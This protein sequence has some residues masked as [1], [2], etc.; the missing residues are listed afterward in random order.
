[1]NVLR[2]FHVAGPMM[3]G[4][5]MLISPLSAQQPKLREIL[6]G[7]TAP[8]G[9]VAFSPDGKLLA[10]CGNKS[11]MLRDMVAATPQTTLAQHSDGLL[12]LAFSPDGRT[13]ASGSK[14]H[15]IV[16]F[17]VATGKLLATLTGHTKP[18]YS[19]AYSPDGKTLASSAEDHLIKL[20]DVATYKEKAT[21]KDHGGSVYSV[22]F[23]PDG[24]TL[25]SGSTDK[26][27]KLWDAA[28]GT[29]RATL[30]GHTETVYC[31]AFSPDGKTLASGSWDHT[32]KLW[33][34]ATGHEK[35]TLKGHTDHVYS[36]AFSPD[37]QTLASGSGW[38]GPNELRVWDVATGKERAPVTPESDVVCTL[39]YSPDGKTL[40]SGKWDSTV[41][42][43]DVKPSPVSAN[44]AAPANPPPAAPVPPKQ[45]KRVIRTDISLAVQAKQA[46][47]RA[48]PYIE[49][50]GT[51]WIKD[52]KC[53]SC[54]YV[55]YMV[56][57]FHDA[58]QRGF[59]IDRAKLAE[60]TDWSM[61]HAI[62]QGSEGPA[63][64]LLARDRT[65]KSEKT[66]TL[67]ES[68]RDAI[69]KVQD[70]DG[71][72][73][74]GGQLPA[75]KRPLSETTQVS[76][77]WNV[78]ALDSID[79]PNEMGIESRDKALAWLNKTPPNGNDPAVSSEW[80]AA[81]LLIDKKFGD[82][83]QVEA[84]RDKILAAQHPDGGWG[85]LWADPSDAFGTGVSLYALSQAGVPNSSAPIQQAWKFLI[86]TQTEEGSWI[87]N[88][89]KTA[90]KDKP[91]P[92]S[93]FWGST[94]ALLGLS[95]SVSD[96]VLSAATSPSSVP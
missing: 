8:V 7:H 10:S 24:K 19:V 40:A 3:V 43:W 82:A 60:W 52:R 21:L 92:F 71:F 76:T 75:Q 11:V 18:V 14:D 70:K 83:K 5:G 22:V 26:T 37:G 57:S 25:A 50:D 39:A 29:E 74:P 27:I 58:S 2:L 44:A 12:C 95:H 30:K 54:H 35:A 59:D 47:E 9:I 53:I 36:V 1:M 96:P 4:L 69:I 55:S 78:L 81:R 79:A 46:A 72:W 66:A 23:S 65:D 67:I 31:V 45:V 61:N 64:M 68:L 17:D 89:T 93:G 33:D 48:I 38:V 73:K 28:Y 13:I 94:W 42:L 56:W 85:F 86:E 34:V 32:C 84:L 49:K 80:H 20:W 63:Q 51:T 62:G 6:R 87:V 15:S 41:T 90:T 91:H 77:M 16:V 88:G